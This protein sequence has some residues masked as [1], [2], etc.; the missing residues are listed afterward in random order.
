M[1]NAA[2]LLVAAVLT[3]A[4]PAAAAAGPVFQWADVLSGSA[5]L[6]DDGYC[7][8]TDPDGNLIVAG[9]SANVG[10][11]TDMYVRKLS[12]ADKSMMWDARYEAFD[13]NDMAVTDMNFDPFGDVLVGGYIRGCVG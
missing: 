9:E 5:G 2:I 10:G 11:G 3:L 7:A 8:L 13:D 1:R 6:L 12:R 4:L